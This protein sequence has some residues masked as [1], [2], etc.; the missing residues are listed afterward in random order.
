MARQVKKPA[1]GEKPVIQK[2]EDYL[3]SPRGEKLWRRAKLYLLVL[4]AACA[5]AYFA[6]NL[7]A[8]RLSSGTPFGF[9]HTLHLLFSPGRAAFFDAEKDAKEGRNNEAVIKYKEAVKADDKLLAGYLRLGGLDLKLKNTQEAFFYFTK[10]HEIEPFNY[11]ACEKLG[12]IYTLKRQ[13]S[14]AVSYLQKAI[15]IAPWEKKIYFQLGDTYERMGDGVA[16]IDAYETSL[17]KL[18]VDSPLREESLK[19]MK[20]LKK[21]VY[22]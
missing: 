13:Y 1:Y 6:F 11:F 19:R 9:K 7:S 17:T 14:K 15:N 12:E 20:A 22:P 2:V 16:A 8:Y 18:P 3:L 5:A 4:A 10:A 21:K